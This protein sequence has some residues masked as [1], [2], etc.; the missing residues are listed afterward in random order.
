VLPLL[1]LV[2]AAPLLQES[3]GVTR[4]RIEGALDVGTQALLRRAIDEADGR[5]DR[6][7][8]E[9]D[10]PGGSTELMWQ[11]AK[12]LNGASEQG[13]A[14]AVWVDDRALSAGALLA[15]ACE[16]VYMRSHAT[17]GSALPVTIGPGGLAPV[18]EDEEVREKISSGLRAEFRGVAEKHGRPGILAE[19]MVDPALE[20]LEVR[21]DGALRLVSSTEL[22]DLRSRGIEHEFLRTVVAEGEL[23][24]ATGSEAVALGLAD[25]LAESREELYGKLGLA[26]ARESVVLR[27]RSEDLAAWLVLFRPLLLIA[28]FVLLYLE[29]KTPGF[30]L[31]GTLGILCFALLLGGQYLVGLADIPHVILITAGAALIAVELFLLPGTLWLGLA[32]ACAILGGLIWSLAGGSV[33]LDYAL[34]RAIVMREAWRVFGSGFA[35]LLVVWGLARAL[36]HTP[37][38]RAFVATPPPPGPA[39]AMPEAGGAHAV[40]A[41]IGATGRALTALRPVG[42]VVLDGGGELDFEARSEGPVLEPGARVR[43]V[44]VQPSGRLVVELAPEGLA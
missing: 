11:L 20:V 38:L 41:R 31:P 1:A 33:G 19:A 12:M 22:D 28:G 8:L 36:P 4:V 30:G 14:T 35:A 15:L 18:S 29:L 10:T 37:V 32:G 16:R 9:L 44:E 26:G 42:K 21:V 24:N 13:V 7:V 2:L 23:F 39:S 3:G 6:L 17:I 27:A 25:G 34:D 5:G 40:V 43:V